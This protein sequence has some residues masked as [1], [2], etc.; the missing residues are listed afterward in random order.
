MSRTYHARLK[1]GPRHLFT[2]HRSLG[3]SYRRFLRECLLVHFHNRPHRRSRSLDGRR[4]NRAWW[5]DAISVASAKCAV[6]AERALSVPFA[7]NV[8]FSRNVPIWRVARP[9]NVPISHVARPRKASLPHVERPRVTGR[10]ITRAEDAQGTPT[11]SHISPSIL[12]YEDIFFCVLGG[13]APPPRSL[14]SLSLE[15]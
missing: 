4:A 14:E 6:F 11:Q 7:R 9:R 2:P 5:R 13:V 8:P 3:I 1:G 15:V 12:A 10:G